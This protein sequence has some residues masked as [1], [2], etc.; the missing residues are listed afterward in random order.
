[1]PESTALP[2]SLQRVAA[3]DPTLAEELNRSI[4]RL[5][6]AAEAL[7]WAEE[8]LPELLASPSTAARLEVLVSAARELTDVPE[9]WA[10]TWTGALGQGP[11]SIAAVAGDGSKVPGPEDLSQ[12]ILAE[13]VAAGRPTWSDDAL[14]DAR[15]AAAQSVQ[16]YGLRSVGCLPVG[17]QGAL[18]LMDPDLPGRFDP[19]SRARLAA[20]ARLVSRFEDTPATTPVP[21]ATLPGLVGETPPMQ[22]LARTV[23]AFAPLPWP[24]LVLGETGTGKE[25]VARALHELSTNA[26]GS[27]VAVNCGAI[28]ADLAESTLFGHERGSFTGADRRR[29]GLVSRANAGTLFLDEVG[30]LPAPLQVKLLR[31]LQEGT[32]ERVG[33][34]RPLKF[35]GRVIAATHRP[36]DQDRGDF[37]DDLYYRLAACIIRTPPLRDRR[38]DVPTLAAHLLARSLEQMPDAPALTVDPACEGWLIAQDWP[39]NVRELENALRGAVGRAL[40]DGADR[41]RPEHFL[42]AGGGPVGPSPEQWDL[43]AA[44]DAFQRDMVTRALDASEG[45]RTRAAVRLGVSRTWLYKLLARWEDVG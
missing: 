5:S 37:R 42:Q 3:Y 13:V 41:I 45:N 23:R 31:L 39:G 16:T 19:V 38:A 14:A 8:R 4:G 36:L 34:D 32:Y 27:F 15:F 20:L 17:S 40:A 43:A 28:P 24:A 12:T 44:T 18:Y 30:E 2:P 26:S 10:A 25:V 9:A 7:V 33:G 21:V 11:V 22:E 6:Q 35:V 29:E 1:M